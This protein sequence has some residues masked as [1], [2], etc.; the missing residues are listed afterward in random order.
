MYEILQVLSKL[1]L[2]LAPVGGVWALG[3]LIFHEVWKFIGGGD[4]SHY[5]AHSEF[6]DTKISKI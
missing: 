1:P 3:M 6:I 2:T 4:F 5:L